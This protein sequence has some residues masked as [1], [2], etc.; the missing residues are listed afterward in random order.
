MMLRGGGCRPEARRRRDEQR[1]AT[2]LN[3]NE[4]RAQNKGRGYSAAEMSRR[5]RDYKA[6]EQGDA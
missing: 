5:Y 4:F 1:A 6:G 2:G 3:W